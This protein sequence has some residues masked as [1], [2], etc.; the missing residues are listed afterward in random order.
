MR[1]IQPR[2][3]LVTGAHGFIGKNLVFRLREEV[4]TE[5]LEFV[6]GDS[7]QVL[8]QL[9][10]QADAIVHLA[11]EN[12]PADIDNFSLGNTELTRTLC[13][14]MT[15]SDRN[16]PLI[17]ASSTQVELDT[18]YGHSKRAAEQLV[19]EF[20]TKTNAP[21]IIFRLPRVFGK[22]SKPN[23]NSVVATF[24][25][26]IAR[27]LEIQV[28]DA[29]TSLEL[30]YVDVLID[31]ILLA[32][33]NAKPG[34]S[35]GKFSTTYTIT[36]GDLA[37][38]IF[39]F[40]NSRISLISERVG[41]GLTRA[42]YSTYI[43]FLPPEQFVYNLPKYGD[44]RGVFVEMLKTPDCGQFSFFTVHPGITR[45]SHYHHSKT[46]KFLVVK[47]LAKMRYRHLVTQEVYEVTIS[48]DTPQVVD[49]IPGWVHDITNIGDSDLIVML[50]ANE[51]FDHKYPDTITQKV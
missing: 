21:V 30:V 14:V 6:R 37:D 22:W 4:G 10:M 25:F 18:L 50:W 48:D 7:V 41:E 39:A 12:R 15:A 3:V 9:V 5:V 32:F 28:H 49:S 8:K 1:E 11:G 44:E 38:Q 47:G 23:Y 20:S 36:V 46:E 51:I 26:N 42:L 27:G 43:S 17:L 31:D 16:I 13:E 35:W 29:E 33:N 2:R 45:G 19:E 40:K 34:L 24:C